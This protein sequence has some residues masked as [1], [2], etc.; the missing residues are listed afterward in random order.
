MSNRFQIIC[1]DSGTLF[2]EVSSVG[3][4]LAGIVT[5][6]QFS[7]LEQPSDLEQKSKVN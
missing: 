4:T 1:R 5:R 7:G 3:G 6:V 2:G